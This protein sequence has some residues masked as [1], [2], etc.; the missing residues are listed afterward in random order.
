VRE[1][2]CGVCVA[3]DAWEGGVGAWMDQVV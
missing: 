2:G 1:G 3:R